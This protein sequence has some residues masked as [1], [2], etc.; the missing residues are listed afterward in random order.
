MKQE[1]YDQKIGWF[2]GL[3]AGAGSFYITTWGE[4][5][6]ARTRY[7]LAATIPFHVSRKETVSDLIEVFG[8]GRL[9]QKENNFFNR[10]SWEARTVQDV[11]MVVEMLEQL[12]WPL[13]VILNKQLEIARQFLDTKLPPGRPKDGELADQVQWA[14]DQMYIEMQE[15]TAWKKSTEYKE[16]PEKKAERAM[17]KALKLKGELDVEGSVEDALVRS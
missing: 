10:V 12:E 3:F 15:L 4:T 2:G 17:K 13:P 5:A 1:D 9:V 6:G 7:V 11:T 8:I 16:P 14:R